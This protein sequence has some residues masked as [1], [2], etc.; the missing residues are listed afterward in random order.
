MCLDMV[1]QMFSMIACLRLKSDLGG[2]GGKLQIRYVTQGGVKSKCYV[3]LHR[4]EG[5]Q[6]LPKS[7]LRNFWT[8]P[9]SKF[10]TCYPILAFMTSKKYRNGIFLYKNFPNCL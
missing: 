10:L 8:A 3:S 7:A 6:K 1:L 2:G 9:N 5:G 4:G